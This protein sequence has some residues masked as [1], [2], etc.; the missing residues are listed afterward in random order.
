MTQVY[1]LRQTNVDNG[2][3]HLYIYE[4]QKY[5]TEE[6]TLYLKSKEAEKK[7]NALENIRTLSYDYINFY[8]EHPTYY[9][10]MYR[11][12]YIKI[13]FTMEKKDENYPPYNVFREQ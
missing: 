13:E 9:S 10:F 12:T 1:K 5:V 11:N 7:R 2:N 3:I 4:C 6:F 8:I